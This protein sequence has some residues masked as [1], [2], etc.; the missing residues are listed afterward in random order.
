MRRVAA[1]L[2]RLAGTGAAATNAAGRSLNP[3]CRFA[4]RFRHLSSKLPLSFLAATL[5]EQQRYRDY[6]SGTTSSSSCFSSLLP[7]V[8]AAGAVG[9]ASVDASFADSGEVLAS[10]M[11][12]T[13]VCL[14]HFLGSLFNLYFEFLETEKLA[15]GERQRLEELLKSKGMQR[16]SYPPFSVDV[17]GPKVA[18]KFKVPPSCD[19]SRLIVDIVSLLGLKVEHRGGGSEMIL[20]AWDSAAAWQLTLRSPEK[21]T[22]NDGKEFYDETNKPEDDF[23][24]IEFIKEGSFTLKEL[25]AFVRVLKLAGMRDVKKAVRKNPGGYRSPP[26]L[27]KSV[28]ALEAM[29]VRVYGVDE[30]FG[31]PMEGMVSWDNIAGYDQQKRQM[32]VHMPYMMKRHVNKVLFYSAHFNFVVVKSYDIKK[33]VLEIHE[34]D[35]KFCREIE[36]T[37]LLAL[38]RPEVYDEIARGTRSKF[39]SNRPRAVLFEGPPGMLPT[40][41]TPIMSSSL[42]AKGF[43]NLD[44]SGRGRKKRA[45]HVSLLFIL[46]LPTQASPHIHA[47]TT[48]ANC[49][50]FSLSLVLFMHRPYPSVQPPLSPSLVP[51][52]RPSSL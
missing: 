15:A 9:V 41:Q 28:S 36:D 30:I 33:F 34:P 1:T 52:M 37:I 10:P 29:G 18:V 27:E 22:R 47:A 50:H 31:V 3:Y 40:K 25:D 2:S 14:L 32:E 12:K 7:I 35:E 11:Q 16:G 26:S 13:L 21:M 38:Q 44:M 8:F 5:V 6:S 48:A 42:V 51:C 4:P 23:C 39:E 46:F 43:K 24:E 45:F 19:V 49:P 20:H 17:R